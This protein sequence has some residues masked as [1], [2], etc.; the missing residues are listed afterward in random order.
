[1][2]RGRVIALV[3]TEGPASARTTFQAAVGQKEKAAREKI[4]LPAIHGERGV[5]PGILIHKK[6]SG[7]PEVRGLLLS[8]GAEEYLSKEEL[9]VAGEGAEA[10]GLA[11]RKEEDSRQSGQR[12]R[13][14]IQ[15]GNALH[16]IKRDELG[17]TNFTERKEEQST[18]SFIHKTPRKVSQKTTK[19]DANPPRQD[20]KETV[21]LGAGRGGLREAVEGREG[22]L[23]HSEARKLRLLDFAVDTHV[24]EG[25]LNAYRRHSSSA[26]R[27][28]SSYDALK[29]FE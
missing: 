5:G 20:S 9:K 21:D 2:E 10:R 1:M 7:K 4:L 26:R 25:G 6:D 24:V 14:R 13:R 15:A 17:M 29:D 16:S 27:Y 22:D 3:A 28:T 19:D 18:S 23:M 12:P 8:I 11:A